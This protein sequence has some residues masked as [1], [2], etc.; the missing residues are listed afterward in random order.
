M[1]KK[2]NIGPGIKLDG[3]KE[4][5]KAISGINSDM[6]VLA[7]EM[8]KTSEQFRYNQNT[9][10]ALTEKDKVLSNQIEKQKEKVDVLKQALENAKNE[11]GE[12]DTRTCLLYTSR[13]V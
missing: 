6:R 3:E 7:S 2:V 12:N 1:A 4:F 8:K 11:Y 10:E 9:V 5:K 13:C